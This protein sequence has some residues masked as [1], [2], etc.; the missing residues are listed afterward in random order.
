MNIV[1]K[2]LFFFAIF[3]SSAFASNS[4]PATSKEAQ[5][6][7]PSSCVQPPRKDSLTAGWYRWEPYQF[8]RT[9][10]GGG[11][12]LS[13]LD[14]RIVEILCRNLGL[15]VKYDEVSWKQHQLD[16]QSGARDIAAGATYTDA[17]S[18]YAYFSIPYRFEEDSLFTLQSSKKDLN[19]VNI[20]E[21]LAQ[22]RLQN[23]KLGVIKGFSY[24]AP[25]INAYIA[26]S[27]NNDIIIQNSSDNNNLQALMRGEIDGFLADRVVGA[28]AILNNQLTHRSDPIVKEIPL[29]IK[30]PIHLMFSKKTVPL[31]FVEKFNK[32]IA[33][34]I[35]TDRF[36]NIVAFYL[37]PVLLQQTINADWFYIVSV[38]GT[39]AFAF[40]GIAIAAKENS[41]LFGTLL[42]AMLPS[43][44]G[45]IM[46]DVMLNPEKIGILLT[47]SYMYYV[48]IIVLIGFATI[49]L[50]NRYNQN[51]DEDS[52]VGKFWNNLLMICDSIGQSAFIITGV[53]IAIMGR[54]T[55]IELWGPFFAFLTANGGGILRD[56]IRKD[57]V[58][59]CISGEIN[60]EISVV[61]GFLF[62][63]FLSYSAHNPDLDQIKYAVIV[64]VC[65]SFLTRMLAHYLKIPNLRFRSE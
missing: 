21:F 17:R 24:A 27:T 45:G 39:I 54:I 48:I 65:G 64:V 51:A 6:I 32:G 5:S 62:A 55:P 31:D 40:S 44:G 20:K 13:G 52:L 3:S 26:D 2:F 56:L 59:T 25:E 41:T 43:V 33:E 14:V 36:K 50:L 7:D 15:D 4:A 23:Y 63:M 16:L 1:L 46:R 29:H 8:N 34:L 18:E 60:A 57:R 28:A 19:F 11:S 58:V 37:Y 30:T 47:P 42:F 53:T 22:I 38:I 9:A 10:S 35:N 49:R 12:V 61:W